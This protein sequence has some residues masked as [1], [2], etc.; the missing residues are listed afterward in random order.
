[1]FNFRTNDNS[2]GQSKKMRYGV[3]LGRVSSEDQRRRGVSLDAQKNNIHKWAEENNVIIVKEAYFDHSAYRG[4][5]EEKAFL[6]LIEYAKTD[7]RVSL[8]IVD[9]KSRF[10]RSRYTRIVYE[11]ELRKA[12]V[13]LHAVSEPNYDTRTVHGVWMDGISITKNE[14]MSVE[15]AYHTRK[16]MRENVAQQDPVT[17]YCYKNGGPAAYGY[18]NVRVSRGRDHRG[19]EIVKLLWEVDEEKKDIVREIVLEFWMERGWT[20]KMIRDWL[21]TQG[22]P[23]PRGGLWNAS[24]AREICLRALEGEY[25]GIAYWNRTG[26]DLRGTGQK[27][28]DP[29][30]WIIV[31]NAHPV[32]ITQDEM[33][34]LQ[35]V[36]GPEVQKRKGKGANNPKTVNSPWLLSGPNALG[37]PFFRCLACGGNIVSAEGNGYKWYLCASYK[38]YGPTGCNKP[39]WIDKQF[40][41]TVFKAIIRRFSEDK[42]KEL[43][44]QVNS[45]MEE[46][47]M[48]IQKA[49]QHIEK[50][51]EKNIRET[52]ELMATIKEAG[53]KS[54]SLLLAE[55]E[56]LAD[57]KENLEK[58][59]VELEKEQPQIKKLDEKIILDRIHNI[60]QIIENGTNKEKRDFIRAFIHSIELDPETNQAYIN[61]FAD[62]FRTT[63]IQTG[64]PNGLPVSILNGGDTRI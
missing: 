62:P 25:T 40:E 6:E 15:I 58:Q 33:E 34:E 22:I 61:F 41:Q 10:A 18:K 43:V 14:A 42:V 30:E 57:Q 35:K 21:N 29:E 16:G 46:E 60:H 28:K 36:K 5:D 24:S 17:G 59:L 4:L 53:T 23:S 9:E 45:F 20:W 11:E 12:G 1:M 32:I 2:K 54:K 8:F 3:A 55:M 27:W 52:R 7:R 37:E 49:R 64:N 44:N 31:K 48:D 51:I 47:Y 38:N 63:K 26:K 13:R 56:A 19:K 39:L 50:E